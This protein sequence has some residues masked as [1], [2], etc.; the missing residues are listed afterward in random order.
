[1]TGSQ[2]PIHI[3]VAPLLIYH[4]YF[5]AIVYQRS[6]RSNVCSFDG[7]LVFPLPYTASSFRRTLSLR[8]CSQPGN[9]FLRRRV[10]AEPLEC[11]GTMERVYDV[12]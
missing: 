9:A 5:E 12:E 2:H 3:M 6:L 11:R 1:M 4:P 8:Q 10:G 7:V